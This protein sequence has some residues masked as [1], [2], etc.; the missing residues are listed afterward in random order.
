MEDDDDDDSN[1][2]MRDLITLPAARRGFL[3]KGDIDF[4]LDRLF[5]SATLRIMAISFGEMAPLA[6]LA[7]DRGDR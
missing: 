1:F 7:M 3:F 5:R 6:P 2:F 4:R